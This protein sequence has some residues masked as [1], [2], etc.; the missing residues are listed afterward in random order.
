MTTNVHT[1]RAYELVGSPAPD[2]LLEAFDAYEAALMANDLQALGELFAPD[3]VLGPDVPTV[4]A[5]KDGLLVGH[6][7]IDEFRRA[8]GG[9]PART[10][11]QVLIQTINTSTALVMAEAELARGGSALQTQLWHDSD[12]R[13][14]VTAAHVS[15]PAPA[16]DS[17][18]W[19]TVGTPL[20]KPVSKGPLDGL[21]IAVKDLYAVAGQ[22]IGAGNEAWLSE[23]QPEQHSAQAVESLL[24][25][26][27][28]IAGIAATDEF[29]YS[30]AGTNAHYGTP[31]NPRAPGRISGGS[32]SGSASAV[33]LGQAHIGL[34]SDTGGSI[35]VPASYQGLFGIRTTHGAV[36]LE[37]VL[38]LAPSF[39]TVGWLTRDAATLRT[40]GSVLLPDASG[41]SRPP[42]SSV[43]MSPRLTAVASPT[44]EATVNGFLQQWSHQPDLPDVREVDFEPEILPV[45]LA[46][47]QV[48]QGFEAWQA[49]GAWVGEHWESLGADVA[50]RFQTASRITAHEY[51]TARDAVVSFRA[52]IRRFVGNQVLVLPAA[53]SVAPKMTESS[54]GSDEI[55]RTRTATMQLTCIAGIGGLP[56]IS[57]PMPTADLIPRGVSLVGPHGRDRDL[58]DLAV[59]LTDL[60]LVAHARKAPCRQASPRDTPSDS[61]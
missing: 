40:V 18:M 36:S 32:S 52:D 38:P 60:G 3:D 21:A 15:V 17:T 5:D 30:L 6:S 13:W 54:I 43:I 56:A 39:D 2:G 19:R 46:A 27:A 28:S 37:G 23:S 12:G 53:S 45:W 20:L 29:A 14:A 55:Q 4:R 26:G 11:R 47:F 7:T 9:A 58:L 34:G 24:R 44:M 50:H 16:V 25:A 51:E 57:I 31:P 10:L 42:L 8:R 59:Q 1:V 33:S 48:V 22:P 61:K 35:R 41:T 49:N